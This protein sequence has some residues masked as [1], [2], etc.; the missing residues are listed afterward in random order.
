MLLLANLFNRNIKL[1][2]KATI[3]EILKL[4]YNVLRFRILDIISIFRINSTINQSI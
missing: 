2:K 1:F 4:N 3:N